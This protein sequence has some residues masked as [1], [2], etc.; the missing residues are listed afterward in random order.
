MGV[1]NWSGAF[2]KAAAAAALVA[3]VVGGIGIGA[4][5]LTGGGDRQDLTSSTARPAPPPKVPTAREFTVAVVVS[6]QNCDPAGECLYT[7]TIEPKYIG[8]HP[9]PPSEL[10]VNYRVL[11]GHQPQDGAFTVHD[12]QARFLKDVTLTGPA[13]AT[14]T[15][16]VV[17]VV[18]APVQGPSLTTAPPPPPPPA[19]P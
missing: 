13:G 10:R 15:A 16:S 14:L 1:S 2:R 18:E 3:M 12:D 17:D 8:M 5:L 11:G 6:A 4:F 9:L 7:Y 19:Q